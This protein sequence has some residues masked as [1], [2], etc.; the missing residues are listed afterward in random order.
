LQGD[1]ALELARGLQYSKSVDPSLA[2][3]A[4]YA[5]NDLHRQDLVKEM[6]GYLSGDLGASLFDVAMFAQA[7]DGKKP[8]QRPPLLGF[9]PLLSQGWAYLR[10]RN[11][12]LPRGLEELPSSLTGS[13]W[14]MFNDSGVKRLR[15]TIFQGA[16]PWQPG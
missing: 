1:N 6:H 9:A 14:T 8:E 7:L 15:G 4:A 16:R 13:L 12:V 5:Y 3:Y 10:A 2:V 11:I